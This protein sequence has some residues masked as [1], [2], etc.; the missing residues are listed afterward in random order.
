MGRFLSSSICSIGLGR[1][2]QAVLASSFWLSL[3]LVPL[4]HGQLLVSL[5]SPGSVNSYNPTTGAVT[6]SPFAV[7]NSPA[8]VS[9][10]GTDVYIASFGNGT[11]GKYSLT[12][13]VVNASLVTG[14]STPTSIAVTIV[15]RMRER[16]RLREITVVADRGI[17]SQKTLAALEGSDPPVGY[18]TNTKNRVGAAHEVR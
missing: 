14:F 16:F 13:A 1:S 7:V 11:I 4:A 8:A 2:F 12:G 10:D 9:S 15:K 18:I 5:N 3:W 17:V 6:Q